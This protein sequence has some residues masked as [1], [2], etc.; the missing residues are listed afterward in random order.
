[1]SRRCGVCDH[2]KRDEIDRELVGRAHPFRYF[3]ERYGISLTS[4]YRHYCEHLPA[5]LAKAQR[6]KEAASADSI[7]DRLLSIHGVTLAILKEARADGNHNTALQAIARAEKQLELQAKLV[8]ELRDAPT[9]NVYMTAEFQAVQTAILAT[10]APHPAI[11]VRVA[12][13]LDRLSACC[14]RASRASRRRRGCSRWT[15]PSTARPR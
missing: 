4:V 13:A 14:V 11:R 6:A 1:M 15:R 8:G 12:D 9:V 5:Q 2:K 10:L 7:L 3:P